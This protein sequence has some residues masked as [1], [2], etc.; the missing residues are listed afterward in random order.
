MVFVDEALEIWICLMTWC[1]NLGKLGSDG[2]LRDLD[3][4][5]DSEALEGSLVMLCRNI[6]SSLPT[7]TCSR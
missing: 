2:T 3:V 7:Q 5:I 6:L 4:D 1:A